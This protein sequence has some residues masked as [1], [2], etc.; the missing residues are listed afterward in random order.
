MNRLTAALEAIVLLAGLFV[1]AV[2][3]DAACCAGVV[4]MHGASCCESAKIDAVARSCCEGDA[5]IAARTVPPTPPPLPT[6]LVPPPTT[7]HAVGRSS[8]PAGT[9]TDPLPPSCA[10]F[11]L[12]ASLLL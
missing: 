10:L 5:V 8:L 3:A 12:H 2:P 9:A 4:E 1:L 7:L 11:T 6:T